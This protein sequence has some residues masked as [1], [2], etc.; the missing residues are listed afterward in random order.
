[1]RATSSV[2]GYCIPY[3][4][5][6]IIENKGLKADSK[7]VCMVVIP[8]SGKIFQVSL[9]EAGFRY[10]GLRAGIYFNPNMAFT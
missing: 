4:K 5:L 7:L 8:F 10:L 3:A 9:A 6:V 2:M 1:M